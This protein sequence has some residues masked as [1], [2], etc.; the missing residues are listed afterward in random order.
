MI[1]REARQAAIDAATVAA[2]A[3]QDP[4]RSIERITD[5]ALTA[6]LTALAS[7]EGAQVVKAATIL[8]HSGKQWR[9]ALRLA[10]GRLAEMQP[11]GEITAAEAE[12]ICRAALAAITTPPAPDE[13]VRVA[14]RAERV[15]LAGHMHVLRHHC[16][17][18]PDID[19]R[20]DIREEAQTLVDKTL[21]RVCNRILRE[22]KRQDW[23]A[24]RDRKGGGA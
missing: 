24:K 8:S 10:D 7:Q 19:Y 21:E 22:N 15:D 3:A 13:A 17:W 5:K 23:E 14:L 12:L 2:C 1:D 18:L 20:E 16:F 6:Y 4:L 11:V 9:L